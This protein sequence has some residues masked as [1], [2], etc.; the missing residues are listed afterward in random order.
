VFPVAHRDLVVIGASSGG[1]EALRRLVQRF[2]PDLAAAVLV[3]VHTPAESVG[4]L[5]KILDKIGPLPAK[6]PRDGERIQP[7]FIYVA[8]PNRHLL[9]SDSRLRLSSGPR[10]NRFRPAIDPLFRTAASAGGSRVIGIVLSGAQNDG[11]SGLRLIKESGGLTM[12]QRPDDALVDSMPLSAIAHVAVDYVL[13]AEGLGERV[14]ALVKGGRSRDAAIR[15]AERSASAVPTHPDSGRPD[16]ADAGSAGLR[17]E[18]ALPPPSTLTCPDC[19]GVLWELEEDG[20]LRYRCHV[21]HAYTA[22]ALESFHSDRVEGAL[23]HALRALEEAADLRRRLATRAG[24]QGMPAIAQGYLA[25]ADD[26]RGRADAVRQL[27]V[28]GSEPDEEAEDA[29]LDMA[30]ARGSVRRA[31]RA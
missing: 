10:E 29:H 9:V 20:L 18:A 30:P 16:P 14:G 3:V 6:H 24:D 23:W 27:L 17:S 19:G 13:D 2:P 4:L 22:E 11:T 7:G 31:S 8:P 26:Y 28:G 21:G 5:P 12:V 15:V 1:I 25:S